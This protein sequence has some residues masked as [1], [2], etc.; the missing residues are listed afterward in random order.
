M[1][2]GF[3][4]ATIG[5]LAALNVATSVAAQDIAAPTGDAILVVSG[6]I[7]T[8]NVD[9]TLVLDFDLLTQLPS[10][11]FET[12]TIWTDGVKT[13][14]GVSLAE[15]A[16][17]TGVTDGQFRA[18]AINDYTVEIPVPDAIEGGP[19]IAYLMDGAEMSVRDKGP[20]WVVYPYDNN[21]DYRAELIYSRSIWQLDRLEIVQ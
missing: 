13:F 2:K 5:L 17:L 6:D 7:S 12:T 10:T 20:L 1:F 15:I 4:A 3:T 11:T 19:I 8:T 16:S 14:T 18:T 21:A 9:D